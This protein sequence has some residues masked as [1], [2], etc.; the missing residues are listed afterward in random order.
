MCFHRIF[1]LWR[2][3]NFITVVKAVAAVDE[4]E[5]K[6]LELTYSI[7]S[8]I[9]SKASALLRFNAFILAAGTFVSRPSIA[10]PGKFTVSEWVAAAL[11]LTIVSMILCLSVVMI[12]WPFLDRIEVTI[13]PNKPN[14]PKPSFKKELESL[15]E[16]AGRRTAVYRFAWLLSFLSVIAIAGGLYQAIGI[17]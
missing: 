14:E 7:L 8:V 16:V 12:E 13:D 2:K 15:S 10:N 3:T 6:P 11:I 1:P 17:V 9:D 4:K 5:R